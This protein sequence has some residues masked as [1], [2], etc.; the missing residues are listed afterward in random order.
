MTTQTIERKD[1]YQAFDELP[2]E[3]LEKLAHYAAFLKYEAWLEEQEDAEDNAYIEAHK[4][5]QGPTVSL[6]E[7]IKDYETKYGSLN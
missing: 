6:D 2:D 1:I 3:S 5:D 4:N 7:V